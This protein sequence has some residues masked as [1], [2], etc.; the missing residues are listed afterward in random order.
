MAAK[1][2][3]FGVKARDSMMRGIDVLADAV[4]C[5]LGPKVIG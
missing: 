4:S 5:T 3:R 1:E 2:I